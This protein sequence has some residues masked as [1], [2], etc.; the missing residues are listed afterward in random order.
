M[1]YGRFGAASPAL[2]CG[3]REQAGLVGRVADDID[4]RRAFVMLTDKAAD[5]MAR[6]FAACES[7]GDFAV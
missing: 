1:S 6:Y 5:A 7:D 4:R 3:Q 2:G